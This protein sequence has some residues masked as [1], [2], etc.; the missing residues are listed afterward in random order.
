MNSTNV[1]SGPSWGQYEKGILDE[2]TL[3]VKEE[4]NEA[5]EFGVVI[6]EGNVLRSRG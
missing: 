4:M 1:K 2:A 3:A 5:C 6:A